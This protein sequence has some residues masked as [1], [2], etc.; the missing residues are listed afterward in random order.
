[1]SEL[2]CVIRIG[3]SSRMRFTRATGTCPYT[4]EKWKEL[5]QALVKLR[6]PLKIKSVEKNGIPQGFSE[7]IFTL[8]LLYSLKVAH[9]PAVVQPR[10]FALDWLTTLSLV[11][12]GMTELPDEVVRLTRLRKLM[13]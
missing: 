8:R 4:E 10:L 3:K 7:E 2:D 6:L 5:C 1:M 12:C 13:T 11:L 9:A